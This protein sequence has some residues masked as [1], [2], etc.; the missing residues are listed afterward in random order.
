[1]KS[2]HV[3]F[4]PGPNHIDADGID[5]FPAHFSKH[6]K[7]FNHTNRLALQPKVPAQTRNGMDVNAGN[8]R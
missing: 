6:L 7:R 1:M 3:V 8:S 4:S 5:E 2:E